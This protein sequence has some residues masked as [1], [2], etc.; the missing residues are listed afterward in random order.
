MSKTYNSGYSLVVTHLTTN[1]PVPCLSTAE[2]TGSAGFMVLWSYVKG[3]L[4]PRINKGDA[5]RL[6]VQLR[7]CCNILS[8]VHANWFFRESESQ[9][10]VRIGLMWCLVASLR[11]LARSHG[12]FADTESIGPIQAANLGFLLFR[13]SYLEACKLIIYLAVLYLESFG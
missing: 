9:S 4:Q 13:D 6:S 11:G 7:L 8:V 3:L 1:P 10:S 12:S 5:Y 2:R